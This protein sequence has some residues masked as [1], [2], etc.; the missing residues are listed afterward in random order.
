M[1]KTI[2]MEFE[3]TDRDCLKVAVAVLGLQFNEGQRTFRGYADDVQRC[4]DSIA[5]PN[6]R[7][8]FEIGVIANSKGGYD[9][10]WD[11]WNG[12][13]MGDR[14]TGLCAYVGQKGE[15]LQDEYNAAFVTKNYE[16]D[17]YN[18]SRLGKAEDGQILLEAYRQ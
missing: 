3:V 4:Q 8:A 10:L 6:N 14:K 12:G 16:T 17:G 13:T 7:E 11:D 18:V 2:I 9:L 1:S 5:I 15:R